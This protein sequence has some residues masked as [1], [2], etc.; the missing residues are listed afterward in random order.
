MT[1]REFLRKGNLGFCEF[2]LTIE[3]AEKCYC[4]EAEYEYVSELDIEE[5]FDT[6]DNL[7]QLNS[8]VLETWWAEIME[9]TINKFMIYS[10]FDSKCTINITLIDS[11]EPAY[12]DNM[13]YDTEKPAYKILEHLYNLE[14]DKETLKICKTNGLDN[15][16]MLSTYMHPGYLD[17]KS[18]EEK[19]QIITKTMEESVEWNIEKLK[20]YYQV[21][22]NYREYL[23]ADCE[24]DEE[25]EKIQ[26]WLKM[27]E[28]TNMEDESKQQLMIFSYEKYR[29]SEESGEKLYKILLIL[30]CFEVELVALLV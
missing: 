2:K 12:M 23:L 24:D 3:D 14:E 18:Q 20:K 17:G 11:D 7:I 9:R 1:L 30:P 22:G 19:L 16:D 10:D 25:K 4:Y 21:Y 6:S 29:E 26:D 15:L 8:I 5:H 27:C 13:K 28:Q